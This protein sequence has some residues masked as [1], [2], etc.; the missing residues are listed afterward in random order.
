[1]WDVGTRQCVYE[2]TTHRLRYNEAIHA[3]KFHP[4]QPVFARHVLECGCARPC[5]PAPAPT[6]SSRFTRSTARC[7]HDMRTQLCSGP[8][9]TTPLLRMT[10]LGSCPTH[11]CRAI[12]AAAAAH[13]MARRQIILDHVRCRL[14]RLPP[15]PSLKC[16]TELLGAVRRV[17]CSA[18]SRQAGRRAFGVH[19]HA[20]P[21]II[22]TM[23]ARPHTASRHMHNRVI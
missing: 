9:S 7:V 11:G 2:I 21:H 3:S 20:I 22:H 14:P 15:A 10:G 17:L 4:A 5:R 16:A 12:A 1:M 23:R 13:V 8:D 19:A 6:P 18:P